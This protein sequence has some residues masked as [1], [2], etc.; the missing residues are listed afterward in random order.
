MIIGGLLVKNEA[1]KWL[2][3]YLEI[4][5]IVCDTLVI[6]D[7]CSTD[8]TLE[9]CKQVKKAVI[10]ESKE[11][12]WETREHEQRK[13]LWEMCRK[14]CSSVE[15]WIFVLDADELLSADLVNLR[16]NILEEKVAQI[17]GFNLYD[18]WD[19]TH[20][21]SDN[22]WTA[23]TR[24]W[25]MVLRNNVRGTWVEG[26]HCGRFPRP[27]EDLQARI[28]LEAKIKHMGWSLPEL[29]KQKYERYMRIDAQGTYG[30]LEQYKSILD[31]NP[32]LQILV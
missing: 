8:T 26:L 16:K 12:L 20:Y 27:L 13:R 30:S 3:Q 6:V 24:F 23:H 17:L 10:Y 11:S 9:I 31:E 14:E 5:D 15:D 4:M 28:F 19:E 22:F 25:P 1:D 18:M 21:R 2:R 32:R 29:R 7:D